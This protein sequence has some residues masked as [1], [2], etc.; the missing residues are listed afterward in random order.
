M[1]P[2]RNRF[3]SWAAIIL[4]LCVLVV[5]I[6]FNIL[7]G[8]NKSRIVNAANT[9][10][11]DQLDVGYMAYV[12][13]NIV[14]IKD[15]VLVPNDDLDPARVVK[16][17]AVT[18]EFSILEFILRQ[19][20]TVQKVKLYSPYIHH[21]YFSDFLKRNGKQL[22]D[23][24]LRLPRVDFRFS[25]KDTLWDF[26][27]G[28]GSPD[29]V[30]LNFVFWMKKD[31]IRVQG[32]ARKDKYVHAPKH[33]T[34]QPREDPAGVSRGWPPWASL[35]KGGQRQA[36]GLPLEFD[37]QGV[38]AGEG[39]F[40]DH[41]SLIRKNV[42]LKLWGSLFREKLQLNGFAFLDT[43]PQE[44]Y[45]TVKPVKQSGR[46]REYLRKA[47]KPVPA[48]HFQDKDLYL[49]DMDCLARISP[50]RVDVERLNFNFNDV[51]VTLK[52]RLLFNDLFSADLDIGLDP[53][54][55]KNFA[56]KNLNE[57]RWH[58][59]GAS[60]GKVFT[61][62]NDIHVSFDKA[63]NPNF[64]VTKIDSTLKGLRFLLDQ[65]ARPSARLKRGETT[66]ATGGNLHKLFLENAVISLSALKSTLRLLEV[67]SPF[68]GGRLA[69]RFWLTTGRPVP[70]VDG[71][72]VLNDVD[73]HQLD[74]LFLDF[75]KAEGR[76]FGRVHLTS[77]PRLSLDGQFDMHNGRLKNFAFFQWLGDT[78]N[79]PSLRQ[80]DF[81]QVSSGFTAD[82]DA[83][84]FKGILLSSGNVNISGDFAI[85]KN[86]L[87]ASYLSLAFSKKL[88]D[89]SAK[90]RPILKIFGED[91]PMVVFDF[92][93]AG[94]Q[95]AMNFQWMPSPHKNMIQERIPNFVER[96]I[97]R[98]I[99]KMMTPAEQPQAAAP[100]K[101]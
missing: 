53:A 2:F 99:D 19:N 93:L 74:E 5:S 70:K 92:Q 55:S 18:A 81:R 66:I 34:R 31:T 51:P 56:M 7:L 72:V 94:R 11:S 48:G 29:Y 23:F 33:K 61:S 89:E 58:L 84:K 82:L 86:G 12:F 36:A 13:P 101:E 100:Q 96:I 46:I 27:V 38:W 32:A 88:L 8:L 63:K 26:T 85:D 64:P 67:K 43:Y 95:E 57:I 25:V 80:V 62:D 10:I 1:P 91:I 71:T 60:D 44:E 79:L 83:L 78:F 52:G 30:Q 14:V 39:L 76:L 50:P 59:A 16:L 68:Y 17:P 21:G 45:G 98:R 6:V 65:Y 90:F 24:L 47:Q 87:V 54:R 35:A 3:L 41:L 22:L 28:A 40:I 15:A 73:V 9:L 49:M 37:F 42:Y 20:V 75:A 97:E 4:V 69:G 77:V